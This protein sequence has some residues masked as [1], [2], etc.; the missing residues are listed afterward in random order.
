MD[1][2]FLR[3]RNSVVYPKIVSAMNPGSDLKSNYAKFKEVILAVPAESDPLKGVTKFCTN[4]TRINL[5][6]QF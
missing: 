1:M 6:A 3:L 5:E 2:V 4:S